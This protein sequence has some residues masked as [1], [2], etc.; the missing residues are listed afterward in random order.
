MVV[1]PEH[2]PNGSAF[3]TMSRSFLFNPVFNNPVLLTIKS[4]QKCMPNGNKCQNAHTNWFNNPVDSVIRTISWGTKVRDLIAR[5]DCNYSCKFCLICHSSVIL[6]FDF[7]YEAYLHLYIDPGLEAYLCLYWG[8]L[9][10]LEAY[11]CLYWGF[12]SGLEAYLCLYWGFLS[13]LEAYLCL[14]WGFLSG[15]EAYLHLY[16]GFLSGL[17]ASVA[18]WAPFSPFSSPS[19]SSSAPSAN[20]ESRPARA[21]PSQILAGIRRAFPPGGVTKRRVPPVGHRGY[22]RHQPPDWSGRWRPPWL[23]TG[24]QYWTS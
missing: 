21:R 16:W 18:F 13:G 3:W 24:E 12:L 15:F 7:G 10:G 23:G 8:F 4:A 6:Y 19:L 2:V 20:Q 17:D 1:Y 5:N 11:L 9:S 14:Y 22:A